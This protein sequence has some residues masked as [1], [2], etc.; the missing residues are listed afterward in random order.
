[1][2][3]NLKPKTMASKE[4]EESALERVAQDETEYNSVPDSP[5]SMIKV[6][7]RIE[8]VNG[9]PLPE[10]LMN[11]QQLNVFCAQYAGE[12]PYHVELLSPYEASIS[13]KGGSCDSCCSW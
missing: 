11:P 10:S 7:I 12:Q 5:I 4:I 1:M 2:A 8:K 3:R 6:L 9:D 13:Y